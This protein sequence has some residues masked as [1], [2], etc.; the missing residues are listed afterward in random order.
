MRTK[1]TSSPKCD[2]VNMLAITYGQF[3]AIRAQEDRLFSGL[4]AATR[5]DEGSPHMSNPGSLCLW[6]VENE[7]G[8]IAVHIT[9]DAKQ[10]DHL[11][12]C[13]WNTRDAACR[14]NAATL[15]RRLIDSG[16]VLVSSRRE[17]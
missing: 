6:R 12:V 1:L 16:A 4:G 9:T 11:F 7:C 17:R 2:D 3:M 5:Y 14:A 15:L 13:V 10:K 8:E